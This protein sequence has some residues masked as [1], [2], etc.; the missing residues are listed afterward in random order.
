MTIGGTA[1]NKIDIDM[2][3]CR[4]VSVAR[5]EDGGIRTME[6]EFMCSD[7]AVSTFGDAIAIKFY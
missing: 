5:G 2:P 4:V 1:G 6:I 7:S 3:R